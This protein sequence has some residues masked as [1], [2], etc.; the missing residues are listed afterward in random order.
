M[1][2]AL[3]VHLTM[4]GINSAGYILCCQL[5]FDIIIDFS[6]QI[7][8]DRLRCGRAVWNVWIIPRQNVCWPFWDKE[9]CRQC[10]EARPC[11]GCFFLLALPHSS[12]ISMRRLAS[13]TS[14]SLSFVQH[15]TWRPGEPFRLSRPLALR[16][17]GARL[18]ALEHGSV[19]L[20]FSS[21][22]FSTDYVISQK[23]LLSSLVIKDPV[24]REFCSYC[25]SFLSPFFLLH[26]KCLLNHCPL[27]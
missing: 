15:F 3:V 5:P 16:H 19:V 8:L 4:R 18:L 26:S 1:I 9:L 6:C 2:T 24:G 21:S 17:L 7:F 22:C 13:G 23:I 27:L 14:V 20:Y 25:V 12:T 10:G 11:G